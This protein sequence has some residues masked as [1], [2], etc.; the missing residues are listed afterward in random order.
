MTI[1]NLEL[2]DGN[3]PFFKGFK[4]CVFKSSS[5]TLTSELNFSF[6]FSS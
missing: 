4:K 2:V 5:I 3:D 1:Y 6:I